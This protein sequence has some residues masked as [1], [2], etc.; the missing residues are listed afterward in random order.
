M[1]AH[2]QLTST[3]DGNIDDT[4]NQSDYK[5]QEG[6]KARKTSKTRKYFKESTKE[7]SWLSQEE[8]LIARLYR[9]AYGPNDEDV[10][11]WQILGDG[12]MILTCPMEAWMQSGAEHVGLRKDIPWTV[13]AKSIDYNKIFF[14]HFLPDLSGKAAL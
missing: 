8:K 9:M 1:K 13:D 14:E 7:F 6:G 5:K 12:E 2:E 4:D 11:D 10:I 3:L